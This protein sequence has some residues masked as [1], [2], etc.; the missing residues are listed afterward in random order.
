MRST[1][2]KAASLV[3]S[4][5]LWSYFMALSLLG[6]LDGG[7][8]DLRAAALALLGA[9]LFPAHMVALKPRRWVPVAAYLWISLPV[10]AALVLA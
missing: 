2:A 5:L 6:D 1:G 8:S 7:G 10:T 3:V 9:C 4:L